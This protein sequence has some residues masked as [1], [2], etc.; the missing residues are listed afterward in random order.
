MDCNTRTVP[1]VFDLETV[2]IRRGGLGLGKCVISA[3]Q[4]REKRLNSLS[5]LCLVFCL[6]PYM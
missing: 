1:V 4:K 5:N 2:A 3:G 6:K